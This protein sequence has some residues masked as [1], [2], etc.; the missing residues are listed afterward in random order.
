MDRQNDRWIDGDYE[1]Y[2]FYAKDFQRKYKNI[3]LHI[4]CIQTYRVDF[5]IN[6]LEIN[7]TIKLTAH[8]AVSST[9]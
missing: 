6:K 9:K 8:V 5:S 4:K 1:Q 7:E 2:L 3:I